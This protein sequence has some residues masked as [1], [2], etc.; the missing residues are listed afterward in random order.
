MPKQ[1]VLFGR[2]VPRLGSRHV[3][4]LLVAISIFAVVSLLF[5]LPGT[6]VA[7]RSSKSLK[8]HWASSIYHFKQPSH[9]PERQS[10]DTYGDSSWYSNFRWLSMPFSSSVTLDHNRQV[11]P[12]MH[13]R[14]A[15][16]C[17]YDNTLV[18]DDKKLRESESDLL[19]AWRR[20]WWAQ[21]FKPV[22]LSA[23]EA[24]NNPRYG[25]LTKREGMDPALLAD[26]MR[27]LAWENMGG[28]LLA[29]HLVF[30]MAP[31]ND[32]MLAFLRR[33]EFP[34]LTMW[35]DL[36]DGL[37]VG[38]TA[39]VTAAIKLA[40]A[41]PHLKIAKD[42]LT[43]L[44]S[45]TNEKIF[46]VD[47]HANSLAYYQPSTRETKYTKV[48]EAM[49]TSSASG[50]QDLTQLIESHLHLTWQS[51]F[52]DGIDVV[53]PLPHHTTHLISPAYQLALRLTRCPATPMPKSCPPNIAQC[54]PCDDE[55]RRLRISTPAHYRNTSTVYTIG[56]V[57]HPYT[58]ASL[59]NPRTHIDVRWVRR[60]SGG[61]DPW[62]VDLTQ[63]LCA[64]GVSAGPRLLRFKEAVASDLGAAHSLWLLAER[65]LPDDLDWHFGF[66]V[67][68]DDEPDEAA[69]RPKTTP[70]KLPPMHDPKDGP[71]PTAEELSLEQALLARAQAI[72]GAGDGEGKQSKSRTSREDAVVRDAV[73]AWN[74]ADVEA[75]RF[76]RA[77]LARRTVERKTWDEAES[78]FAGGMGSERKGRRN[79]WNRWLD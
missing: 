79:G 76:T 18:K 77:V 46:T 15:I 1:Y 25:E 21:G 29:S 55:T 39:E 61:R 34:A 64:R 45:D 48:A 4:L 12:V 42:F 68:D 74:L 58:A 13:K 17:Y 40:M 19:L 2:P 41:S 69:D 53:K 47:E 26:F 54:T 72:V 43:T 36:G 59:A 23:A 66:A 16:Y 67:P 3:S 30:P 38:P 78:K 71:Q 22:I 11:L 6:D 27:W 65:D 56:T 7:G 14:P 31:Y 32:P 62:V 51:F 50:V 75:W 49:T 9:A 8:S 28:G 24:A 60:D 37:F 10:N 57:P 35:K 70:P 73:E 44:S 33:G 52:P 63:D 20:A 5:T